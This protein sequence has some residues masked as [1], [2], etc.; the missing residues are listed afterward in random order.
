MKFE[1]VEFYPAP[2]YNIKKDVVGTVHIYAIDCQMDIRGIVVI[3]RGKHLYFKFPHF[4]GED[5]ETK[6]RTI[7]PYIRFTDEKT[8][9]E[10]LDFLH[11]KVAK[12]IFKKKKE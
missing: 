12:K 2:S 11:T 3:K 1:F 6:K 7:Y 10:L 9:Q 4:H 8:H 5:P